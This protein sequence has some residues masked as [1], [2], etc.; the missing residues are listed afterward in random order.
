MKIVEYLQKVN[1]DIINLLY[2]IIKFYLFI[3]FKNKF[4]KLLKY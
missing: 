3:K 1:N 2:Y 4:K